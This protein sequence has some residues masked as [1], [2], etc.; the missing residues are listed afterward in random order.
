MIIAVQ[1]KLSSMKEKPVNKT[2]ELLRLRS[3][4]VGFGQVSGAPNS[5]LPPGSVSILG[6]KN[7]TVSWDMIPQEFTFP[8]W[9]C[10]KIFFVFGNTS[11]QTYDVSFTPRKKPEYPLLTW[12]RCWSGNEVLRKITYRKR[13]ITVQYWEFASY[14]VH[15]YLKP[16]YVSD[17]LA[18]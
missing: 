6:Q 11:V 14:P 8:C 3:N 5:K 15:Y 2:G 18:H 4:E 17:I 9:G 13:I 10:R 7:C 12:L 1:V 16:K